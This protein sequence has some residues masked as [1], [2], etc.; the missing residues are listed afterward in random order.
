MPFKET[1]S[2][3]NQDSSVKIDVESL[4]R[5]EMSDV[6]FILDAAKDS[7]ARLKKVLYESALTKCA[8][9]WQLAMRAWDYLESSEELRKM[10]SSY[11][12]DSKQGIGLIG[13]LRAD[14]F[15]S[16]I[17]FYDRITYY[18]FGE[19]HGRG[20]V[21][22]RVK[23]NGCLEVV[24]YAS[25]TS[26]ESEYTI[27][28]E[29]IYEILKPDT[30]EEQWV[31]RDDLFTIDASDERKIEAVIKSGISDLKVIWNNIKKYRL[32]HL[33]HEI[34]F[35]NNGGGWSILEE[36]D[37]KIFSYELKD[38]SLHVEGCLTF[39]PPKIMEINPSEG[40][41]EYRCEQ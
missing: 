14:L 36:N 18:P 41:I 40:T 16:G 8:T 20:Y 34:S 4:A 21:A 32:S 22:I 12:K 31:K 30:A 38:H 9:A 7:N 37:D 17:G 25:L 3:S 39:H 27:T 6:E 19:V 33:S 13:N 2:F 23:K 5:L 1:K 35:L 29:G 11:P 26:K 28:S 10:Q 15:H 24:G